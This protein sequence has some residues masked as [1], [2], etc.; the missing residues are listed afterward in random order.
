MAL[1]PFG[2]LFGGSDTLSRGRASYEAGHHRRNGATPIW[3][4]ARSASAIQSAVVEQTCI[5]STA[6]ALAI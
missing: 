5:W 2:S 1:D 6:A 4:A 3:T